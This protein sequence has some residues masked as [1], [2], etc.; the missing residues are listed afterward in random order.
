LE[1]FLKAPRKPDLDAFA[2][3]G[4]SFGLEFVTESDKELGVPTKVAKQYEDEILLFFGK[5]PK[6]I[7]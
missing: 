4:V 1:I 5:R 2:G 7:P 6:F 3:K